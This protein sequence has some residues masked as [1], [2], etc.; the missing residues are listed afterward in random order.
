M[1][2]EVT[3]SLMSGTGGDTQYNDCF[4]IYGTANG[5]GDSWGVRINNSKVS[6]ITHAGKTTIGLYCSARSSRGTA[7]GVWFDGGELECSGK[8]MYPVDDKPDEIGLCSIGVYAQ[9]GGIWIGGGTV[10]AKGDKADD[11]CGIRADGGTGAPVRIC[12][13]AGLY[14]SGLGSAI[15]G[16]VIN[17]AAG[18]GW[19][20]PEGK[21]GKAGIAASSVGKSLT[22]FKR[23]EF[24]PKEC[25]VSA[26]VNG[27][28]GGTVSG[29]GTFRKGK[30]VTLTATPD[31]GY[32]FDHWKR[33]DGTTS[34]DKSL[35]FM[36]TEDETV[37]AYFAAYSVAGGKVCAPGGALLILAQYQNGRMSAV[38]SVKLAADCA[39]VD[40]KTLLGIGAYPD[41][42]KLML[43]NGKTYAPLCAA[44]SS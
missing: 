7:W 30:T 24:Q 20:D 35:A 25:A 27:G 38:R 28:K 39:N 14:A 13:G 33:A 5:C 21:E 26:A 44:W 18:T 22:A 37:T 9:E 42:S 19:T 6:G 32:V 16:S 40:A 1:G 2:I 29:A 23:V 43:V 10:N 12:R 17:E 15:Y 4:G 8:T 34:T 41:G 36:V 31:A 11:S 3:G